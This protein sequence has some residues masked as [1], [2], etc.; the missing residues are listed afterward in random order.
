M[1][2][3]FRVHKQRHASLLAFIE[4]ALR[5]SGCSTINRSPRGEA[6]LRLSF[7]TPWGERVGII[8]YAFLFNTRR[9]KNRPDDEHRF[10]VKYGS[11]G[12]QYHDLWQDPFGLCTT[13]FLGIN[14]KKGIFVGADPV[15]NSPTQYLTS[16]E[17]MQEHVD[18]IL[19]YGWHSWEREL[20]CEL[21][22][23]PR[24]VLIGGTAEHFLRYVLFEREVVGE[25]QGHRQLVAEQYARVS[26]P[27]I[28][29]APC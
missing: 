29:T 27:A 6:P 22:P 2:E 14:P 20:E 28:A 4:A 12:G 1:Y 24:E 18:R 11:K 10:Q 23:E 17:F 25:D 3:A 9:T 26:L 7:I 13:L 16:K 5:G 15:L 19:A 21:S 8:A